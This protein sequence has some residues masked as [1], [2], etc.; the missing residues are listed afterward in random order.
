MLFISG[1][2]SLLEANDIALGDEVDKGPEDKVLLAVARD[3][4]SVIT[5]TVNVVRKKARNEGGSGGEG[6]KTRGGLRERGREGKWGLLFKRKERDIGPDLLGGREGEGGVGGGAR[7]GGKEE[8]KGE[9]KEGGSV[10]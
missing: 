1:K 6:G 4:K 9:K 8:E 7:R 5:E 10:D 3:V 2:V